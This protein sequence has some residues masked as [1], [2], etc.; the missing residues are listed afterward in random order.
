MELSP[1]TQAD[2]DGAAAWMR[3]IPLRADRWRG[4]DTRSLVATASGVP[5]AAGIMWTSRVHGDRYWFEIAVAPEHRRRGVARAVFAALSARRARPIPFIARGYVDEDRLAFA[6]A[7]G[8]RTIQ[9]VPPAAVAVSARDVLR[10]HGAVRAATSASWDELRAANA[11]TYE[12]TH[13]DWSPVGPDF[14]LALNEDLAEELDAEAS[15]IAVVDGRI[16][17]ACLV[18]RDSTPPVVTAETVARTT[19]DGELL[20]EGCVRRSLEVLADRGTDVAEF[21]GHVS[22]PHFLPVWTR[23]SPDGRWFHL[24]EVPADGP[25]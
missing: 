19:P 23:L 20:V 24:V 3:G 21:D 18:Y 15:S 7:L 6:R 22:D 1:L 9:V 5:V 8:A 17:A 11:A 2:I 12:W 25:G 16:A 4:D 13:A 14:S 10:S